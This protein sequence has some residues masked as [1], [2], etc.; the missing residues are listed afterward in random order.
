MESHGYGHLHAQA[1]L[2]PRRKEGTQDCQAS[3]NRTM[4]NGK[5]MLNF[6]KK[7]CSNMNNINHV[8]KRMKKME[9]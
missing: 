8:E 9:K 2:A 3:M 4:M 6:E 5:K 7:A 1:H